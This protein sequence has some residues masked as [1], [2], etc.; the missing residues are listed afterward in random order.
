MKYEYGN[1]TDIGNESVGVVAENQS[2]SEAESTVVIA[3]NQSNAEM[4]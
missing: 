2:N 3:E 4:V 1:V